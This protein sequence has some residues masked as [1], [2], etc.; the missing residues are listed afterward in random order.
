MGLLDYLPVIGPA[1][2]AAGGVYAANQAYKGQMA[3]NAANAQQA[4]LNRQWQERMS[5]TAAQRSV[6]DYLAAGLNPALA[7]DRTASTPGGAQATM[8]NP[9][10]ESANIMA[11]SA[12]Q[13]GS[14][15]QNIAN[16]KAT[17]AQTKQLQLE[18]LARAQE[19]AANAMR[20]RI[21]AENDR[22][23]G[24]LA[25]Q[26]RDMFSAQW[27]DIIAKL[28]ADILNVHS[29]TRNTDA[30]TLMKAFQIPG[31]QNEANVNRSWYGRNIRPFI[32]DAG[33]LLRLGTDITGAFNTR[34]AL[35]QS[36]TRDSW[37]ASTAKDRAYQDQRRT[38]IMVDRYNRSLTKKKNR[39]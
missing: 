15:L 21:G 3:T 13:V 19:A 24:D 36:A 27:P 31:L 30:D 2:Q 32:S 38:D 7:Y 18:S 20:A 33:T 39:D 14:A 34:T 12:A 9:R 16:I 4:D 28:K 23:S 25:R 37:N 8:Q 1:I 26:Q 5:N 6:K 17:Q 22:L 35:Q 10:G 11:N 29:N